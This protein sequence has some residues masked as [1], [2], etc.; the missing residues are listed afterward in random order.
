[1]ASKGAWIFDVTEKEF[2]E[3]VIKKSNEIPVVVD[4]W[5]PWCGPCRSLTP[6]LEL[7]PDNNLPSCC[8]S[9]STIKRTGTHRRHSSPR[10]CIRGLPAAIHRLIHE[11]QP[12]ELFERLQ[13]TEAEKET[14]RRST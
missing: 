5:A 4:F 2:E 1:M 14:S 9:T 3:K 7:S 13:P 8:Q 11:S 6:I 12:P 10:V